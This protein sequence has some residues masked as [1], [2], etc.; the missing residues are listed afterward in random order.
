VQHSTPR[1]Y[2]WRR[3]WLPPRAPEEGH[4]YLGSLAVT[5]ALLADADAA[6]DDAKLR[7]APSRSKTTPQCA[8]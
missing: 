4:R 8:S 7:L 2:C 6:F 3:S 5:D 1:N